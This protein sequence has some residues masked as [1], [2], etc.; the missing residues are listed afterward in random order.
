MSLVGRT[1]NSV[2][3][4]ARRRLCRDTR[5]RPTPARE[6]PNMTRR[7]TKRLPLAVLTV[8][9][10]GGAGFFTLAPG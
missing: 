2:Q 5:A 3:F 8:L 10:V 7:W 6:D 9:V 4:A 1:G